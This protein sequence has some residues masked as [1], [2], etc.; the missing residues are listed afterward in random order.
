M[1]KVILAYSGGLDTSVIIKWLKDKYNNVE[2][3]AFAADVGQ[4]K[5]LDPLEKK[6]IKTGASKIYIE[7]LKQEFVESYI[8][9]ALKAGAMY[10]G[11][12]PLATALSRPLIAKRM[13]ELAKQ[14]NADAVV[15]GCTGKG[16]DQVRFDVT[17]RALAPELKIIAPL[18]EWELKS[19]EEEIEYAKKHD[20]DV[21]VTKD[22][23]YSMDLNLWGQSIECGVLEDPWHEPPE[24]AYQITGSPE[25]APEKARHIEIEFED[26]VPIAL[27]GKLMEPVSLILKLNEIGGKYGVGRIDM[28]E[29]RL[30]GI[31]SREIYE[32][33]AAVILHAAHAD[34][35]S[36]TMERE[37][38]HYKQKIAFD[39]AN[40]IY[41]GQWFSP[42][43]EALDKFVNYTQEMVVG[44]VKLKL[45]KGNA[46]VVGRK[47]PY[48][49]YDESLA[50]YTEK[51]KFDHRKAE[52]FIKLWGLPIEISGI[53]DRRVKGGDLL[54]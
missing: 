49:L 3:V 4:G 22:N 19:R 12:Y 21:P 51:D 42:L 8:F 38:Y 28:I 24:N 2:V 50:T 16:N 6:A 46:T 7:D 47:S 1:K 27:D 11:K 18:R 31:K 48:S 5:D 39:Y 34:L 29:N 9:P 26:G 15:H 20:I 14:E 54:A 36:I 23:P 41:Y 30:V 53:R 45:Y 32:S 10:E 43:R 33:P 52:G 13:I 25:D 17:V 35:E 37:L 44:T 40:L